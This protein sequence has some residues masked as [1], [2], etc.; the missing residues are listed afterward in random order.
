MT[1]P[2]RLRRRRLFT[3]VRDY[4]H[5]DTGRR[6]SVVITHHF[7]EQ[8]YY[9]ELRTVVDRRAIG[10]AV[11]LCE[12]TTTVAFDPASMTDPERDALHAVTDARRLHAERVAL[13]GWVHQPDGL[14]WPPPWRV[15]DVSVLDMIRLL[16]PQVVTRQAAQARTL[17]GFDSTN[18]AAV[19]RYRAMMA[20]TL[21]R[22]A[23][24]VG[25]LTR[26]RRSSGDA[27]MLHR[28]NGLAL[29]AA[30]AVTSSGRDAVLVW[31]TEHFSGLH[32]G[33]RGWGYQLI[34]ASWHTVGDV[35]HVRAELLAARR[36]AQ[37]HLGP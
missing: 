28:R 16:G 34:A 19:H 18:V 35:P 15:V 25:V 11:V 10:G 32:N 13:L 33:L 22:S 12:G 17:M 8:S 6:V 20:A 36:A 21:H 7:G 9:D 27:A 23:S 14:G 26:L 3:P 29:Q 1:T 30:D 5:P 2:L 24:R 37:A 31:G 4:L